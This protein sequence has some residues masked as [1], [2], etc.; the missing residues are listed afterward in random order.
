MS[1]YTHLHAHE[2][3]QIS[4]LRAQG[5]GPTAIGQRLGRSKSTISRELKR[6]ALPDG[7]Y[8]PTYA[9]GC[10]VDRRQ[11]PSRLD[12]DKPLRRFVVDRLAEGWTPEQIAGRLKTGIERLDPMSLETIYAWI[13]SKARKAER[14]WR[15]LPRR[16]GTR[17]PMRARRSRDAI[18]EKLHISERCEAADKRE[19]VGHFESDLV[20][21][22]RARPVLVL[23]ERKTRVTFM[24]RLA[25]K[26]AGETIAKLMTMVKNLCPKLRKSITFDNG[27]EFS[28]HA[29]LRGMLSHSTYFCD[30]YASWQKGGIEN[31]NGRAR[32]WLPR[33]IDLDE[34]TDADIEEIT[35][36]MNLTPR[37]CLGYKTPIEAMLKELGKPIQ[38]RFNANVAL[39][40]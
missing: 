39:R 9:D 5:L 36:T 7:A 24:A 33:G 4:E 37:K 3:D 16:R 30:A 18:K 8:R 27:T 35:M 32:R 40:T 20:I 2:R 19:E 15:Y 17:R 28:Q 14:L 6:N 23:H 12:Q 11:R 10:Y 31:T 34:M 21:C 1:G 38:I 22:K 26:T 25:G 13:Y 29:L